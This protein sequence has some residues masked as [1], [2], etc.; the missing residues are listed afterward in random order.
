MQE[1]RKSGEDSAQFAVNELMERVDGD[2]ELIREVL[3]IFLEDTPRTLEALKTGISDQSPE[4]VAK[5]AHTLKGAS[6]NI[7]ANR[8][9]DHAHQLEL[10]AKSGELADAGGIY[11]ELEAEYAALKNHLNK[12][13]A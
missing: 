6:A 10:K 4:A 2:D 13:L 12:Y 7:A 5:A 9:R 1:D 8:L 3:E 11:A